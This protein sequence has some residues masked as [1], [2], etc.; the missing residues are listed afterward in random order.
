MITTL[1]TSAKNS[2]R[3]LIDYTSYPY[4]F[5]GNKLI[6]FISEHFLTVNDECVDLFPFAELRELSLSL[7]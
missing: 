2:V 4:I 5:F 1:R 7:S 3:E 6:T